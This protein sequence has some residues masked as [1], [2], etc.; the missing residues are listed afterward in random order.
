MKH[1]REFYP[2]LRWTIVGGV[3]ETAWE[4]CSSSSGKCRLHSISAL[5]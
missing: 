5:Y 4:Y 3:K 2:Y 1:M